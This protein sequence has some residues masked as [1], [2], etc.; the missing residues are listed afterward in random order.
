M[1][2]TAFLKAHA[3]NTKLKKKSLPEWTHTRIGDSG[4]ALKVS[5][6]FSG[7]YRIEEHEEEAFRELVYRDIVGK[8]GIE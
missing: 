5:K 1:T 6:L 4:E 8:T 3:Q 2:L 7:R